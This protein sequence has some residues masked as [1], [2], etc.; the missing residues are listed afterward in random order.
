[1]ALVN[2]ID[3]LFNFTGFSVLALQAVKR[4]PEVETSPF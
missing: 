2:A 3:N 1:M 4:Q